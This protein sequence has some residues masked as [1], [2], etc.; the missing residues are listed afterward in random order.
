MV[1]PVAMGLLDGNGQELDTR[2]MDET[3]TISGT[4]V[5]LADRAET[6]FVFADVASPPTPS[7]FRGFSAP[8]RLTGIGPD[9]LRFLAAHDTDPF[10]RWDSGQQYATGA[11]LAMIPAWN[12]GETPPVDAGLIEAMAEALAHAA[13][14][15]AFAAEALILPGEAFLADQ[16]DI[17]D[18]DG[19]HAVR[20][21]ARQSIAAALRDRF[22]A[23]Y[24]TCTDRGPYRI[25]GA[26]IGARSLRNVCLAY[27]SAHGDAARARAQFDTAGN[28]TDELAALA[29]LAGIEGADRTAALGGFHAK[30]RAEPLVLDKWFAIQAGAPLPDTLAHVRALTAHADFDFRNPNRL[31]ALIGSFAG[32][33]PRFHDKSGAGYRFLADMVIRID[34]ANP[35]VAAR[36]VRPLGQWRR[37]ETM[38]RDLMKAELRRVLALPGLSAN[39]FEMVSKSLD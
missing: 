19:I 30:W 18:I 27:L 15:P 4:R 25:E 12:K 32:N 23:A 38:R 33:Q 16:M 3:E 21:I 20:D 11:L 24:E 34:P 8:V 7:L 2:L 10:V 29:V 17:A 13:V 6:T 37:V 36:L 14:D 9:R 28:M 5:L 39:T 26:A 31:G 35:Q 22:A 1:I